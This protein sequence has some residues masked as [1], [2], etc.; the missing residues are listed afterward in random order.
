[1]GGGLAHECQV[2]TGVGQHGQ[3][4]LTAEKG[5]EVRRL[6]WGEVC[7][8]CCHCQWQAGIGAAKLACV[9]CFA[10]AVKLHRCAPVPT[11]ESSWTGPDWTVATHSRNR[12]FYQFGCCRLVAGLLFSIS[13]GF[14]YS[15]EGRC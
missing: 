6:P 4:P 11:R 7:E 13:T 12:K 3:V 8:L 15:T 14:T 2:V 10:S 5:Q 1:M 9:K